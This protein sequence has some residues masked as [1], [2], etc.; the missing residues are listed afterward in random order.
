MPPSPAH[1][2]RSIASD[3]RGNLD[4]R[5][6]TAAAGSTH[7]AALAGAIPLRTEVEIFLLDA[8][9]TALQKLATSELRAAAVLTL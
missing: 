1:W 6:S 4:A 2:T 7:P 3:S 8:A 9:A 5:A